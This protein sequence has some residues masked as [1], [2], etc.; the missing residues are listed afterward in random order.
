MTYIK[1]E[2]RDNLR[3]YRYSGVDHSLLSKYVLGPYWINLVKLFPTS[4][5]PNLITLLGLLA[6]V[7]NVLTL[8]YLSPD[9][10]TP[11]PNWA[12]YTFAIG[13]FVYQSFDA[14]DGKQ[15]RRTG[16]SGPLG[17]LFDHGCDA[18]NTTLGG[19]L[20]ISSLNLQG[21]WWALNSV[22]LSAC[23]FYLSTWEE[24]YTGTL[25]LSAFSGPV[26]GVII[27]ISIH[28]L[29][30]LKGP[31]W[32]DTGLR[33]GLGLS[34]STLPWLPNT[35]YNILF[36]Y[37]GALGLT[38]NTI[39]AAINVI[40]ARKKVNKPLIAPFLNLVP[41]LLLVGIVLAW[42]RASP[43]ILIEH[44][45]SFTL[46]FG[47]TFGYMVGGMILAHVTK[48]PFPFYKR[49]LI[50]FAIGSINANMQSLFNIKPLFTGKLEAYYIYACLAFSLAIYTHFSLSV[51]DELC[52]YFDINCLTIK[53]KKDIK[54]N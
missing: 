37:F 20:V 8:I 2:Y 16:T 24:Y 39:T 49:N 31:L 52:T 9:Y 34:A 27:L 54:A 51:I 30:G 53:K 32:W 47:L 33:D 29:S 11:C 12:Y 3:L 13:L 36:M 41:Y 35:P 15:A 18:L 40:K 50:P 42:V 19:L 4:V 46:F 38:F 25:Y 43:E 23:N 44:F 7:A 21:T 5:A 22:L 1:P 10:N 17:E 26:E 14:I 45:V 28:F 48:A 6:V